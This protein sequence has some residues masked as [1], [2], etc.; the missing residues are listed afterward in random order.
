MSHELSAHHRKTLEM[1]LDHHGHANV[2][3]K[4]VISLLE[5]V[6][7]VEEEHNGKFKVKLGDELLFLTRPKHKDVDQQTLVDVRKALESAGVGIA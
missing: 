4:D 5:Q 2:E 1:L 6:A 3:W 7:D